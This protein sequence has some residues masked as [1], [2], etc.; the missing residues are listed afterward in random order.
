MISNQFWSHEGFT[1]FTLYFTQTH[2]FS[3]SPVHRNP[4]GWE[5]RD[6]CWVLLAPEGGRWQ[7]SPWVSLTGND[8]Q[9]LTSSSPWHSNPGGR[10]AS[11]THKPV[12]AMPILKWLV[13]MRLLSSAAACFFLP[14]GN[15]PY[16]FCAG[17]L[18]LGY[19][20]LNQSICNSVKA[21]YKYNESQEFLSI[22]KCFPKWL[23]LNFI[24][25][26]P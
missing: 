25:R 22:W 8:S 19:V 11:V 15:G 2:R 12:F 24:R 4:L 20:P 21:K 10:K 17:R 7:L 16:G 26:N 18:Y 6:H 3:K 23:K 5:C 13:E 9:A 1:Q 14:S